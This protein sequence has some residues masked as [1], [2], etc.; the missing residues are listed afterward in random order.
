MLAG[1]GIF[2]ALLLHPL[3]FREQ[4]TW[5]RWYTRNF[6]RALAPLIVLLLL[7]LRVRIADYGFTEERDLGV[8]AG[9]WIMSWSLVLSLGAVRRFAGF[10]FH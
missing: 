9:F 5:T 8:V 4:E 1:V 6:P 10:R 2:A 7:S 3:R